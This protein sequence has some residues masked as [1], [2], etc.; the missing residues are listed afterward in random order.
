[1]EENPYIQNECNEPFPGTQL[2]V[3]TEEASALPSRNTAQNYNSQPVTTKGSLLF[4]TAGQPGILWFERLGTE[5]HL[6]SKRVSNQ[7]E[8]VLVTP[9][10]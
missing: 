3:S 6:L 10:I 4:P 8:T 2:Q 7:Q 9:L 1:M 5:M